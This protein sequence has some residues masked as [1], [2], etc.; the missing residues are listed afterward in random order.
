MAILHIDLRP[1]SDRSYVT[2]RYGWDN[3]NRH[4]PRTLP[5]AEI[6]D[7]IAL[8]ERDYYGL[9]PEHFV[10]TGQRLYR[11]LDGTDRWLE[12]TL[13]EQPRE[14]LI[15]LAIAATGRLAHLPWKVLRYSQRLSLALDKFPNCRPRCL[16][17]KSGEVASV[18][19]VAA[20]LK[21]FWALAFLQYTLLRV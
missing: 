7:L 18:V 4:S 16:T 17:K 14:P 10:T 19:T 6:E 21:L 1:T 12:R 20:E 13:R 2:L 5:L 8:M 15:A 9:L 3:L 11:W